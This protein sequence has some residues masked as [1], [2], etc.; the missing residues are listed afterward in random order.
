M[1]SVYRFVQSHLESVVGKAIK[2]I[3]YNKFTLIPT[4]HPLFLETRILSCRQVTCQWSAR[5]TSKRARPAGIHVRVW[6]LF[7]FL[8]FWTFATEFGFTVGRKVTKNYNLITIEIKELV[9]PC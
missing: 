8:C 5:A 6:L 9:K 2:L 4:K 1:I 3:N 7:S